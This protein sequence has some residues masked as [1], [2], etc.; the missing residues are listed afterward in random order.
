MNH[1]TEDELLL[2]AYDELAEPLGS[3]ITSHVAVCPACGDR[4]A[5]LERA[6]VALDVALPKPR[7]PLA[8][9]AALGA[10]AA[11]AA[12]AGVLLTHANPPGQTAAGGW[13]PTTVWSATAGYVAGGKTLVDIDAQLTRLEQE[14]S[15]GFPN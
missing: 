6:R 11:A 5:Q 2:L 8:R 4:L 13:N 1:P 14:R 7:R 10:L 9:W 12:V 15:Y 3:D